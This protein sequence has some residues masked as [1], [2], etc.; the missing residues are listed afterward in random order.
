MSSLNF[1]SIEYLYVPSVVPKLIKLNSNFSN[2]IKRIKRK[3]VFLKYRQFLSFYVKLEH[4]VTLVDAP[5]LLDEGFG[6]EEVSPT[7][8]LELEELK[9]N[10]DN[11]VNLDCLSNNWLFAG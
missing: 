10:A 5:L 3:L 2:V 1:S 9:P 4:G 6:L 11:L 7:T 8:L